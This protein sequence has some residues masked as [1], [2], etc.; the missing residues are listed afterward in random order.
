MKTYS[1]LLAALLLA[2]AAGGFVACGDSKDDPDT[3]GRKDAG[4][5]SEVPEDG[6]DEDTGVENPEGDGGTD[7]VPQDE[8]CPD[9]PNI[10]VVGKFCRISAGLGN[11]IKTD[12]ELNTVK[13]KE[14]YLIDK[15]VFVGEDVGGKASPDASKKS[16]TLTI[17]KGVKLYGADTQSFLLVNRG[18]KIVAEGTK[19]SPIVFTSGAAGAARPGRWGGVIINGRAPNNKA[20]ANGDVAGEAGTGK[21]SGPDAEDN[22]GVIKYVRIEF[23]GSKIDEMN[24]LNGLALQGVGRQTEIDYLHVHANDDDGIEFFGGTVDAKHVIITGAA[25]DGIDWTDGWSGRLQFGIVQ[26]WKFT[27]PGSGADDAANGVEGDSNATT[28][29]TPIS[30]PTL[31]NV[32]LIGDKSVTNRA[33]GL[34]LR[35]G[36]QA[37]LH[38]FLVLNFKENCISLRGTASAAY[39]GNELAF[40]SSQMFCDTPYDSTS[41]AGTA[42]AADG[43]AAM[44]AFDAARGNVVLANGDSSLEDPSNQSKN[45]NFRAKDAKL[46]TGG[47]APSDTFFDK[48]E[49]IGALGDKEADDWTAGAWFKVTPFTP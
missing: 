33:H 41:R 9:H 5:D 2:S 29:R 6:S 7:P 16:A 35:K 3:E 38:N 48:V 8:D 24:E 14:G 1:H 49:F 39:A 4:T 34:I 37:Q 17:S 27:N 31:S 44:K 43:A 13:G 23:G 15:G 36:T 11:E 46:L 32:T 25:D 47:K 22:S 20:D 45:G 30:N 28:T 42:E 18:S 10:T 12:L 26:Q 21:Y 19:D 40:T